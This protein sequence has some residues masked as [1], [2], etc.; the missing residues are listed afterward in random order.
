MLLGA[1]ENAAGNRTEIYEKGVRIDNTTMNTYQTISTA[2]Y[3]L[4]RSL[5]AANP[6]WYDGKIAEVINFSGRVSDTD[7]SKI[8]SYL[9]F[10][11]GMTLSGGTQN[12]VASD[13]TTL[14]WSTSLAG[15]YNNAV[16]GIGRDL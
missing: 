15:S 9:A 2:D 16:F 1:N 13:G 10:K 8:E 12:Y 14:M 11:Y 5:D 6:Y 7:R 4:G 3:S